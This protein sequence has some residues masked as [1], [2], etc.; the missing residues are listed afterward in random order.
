MPFFEYNEKN[1]YYDY[2]DTDGVDSI[3]MEV[4]YEKL[5]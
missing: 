1:K 4:L 2:S 5:Y 3:R